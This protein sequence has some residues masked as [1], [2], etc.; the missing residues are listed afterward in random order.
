MN[1]LKAAIREYFTKRN[2][3]WLQNPAAVRCKTQVVVDSLQTL[4]N[5]GG[6]EVRI[7]ET[8]TW[9]YPDGAGL[10]VERRLVTHKQNWARQTNIWRLVKQQSSGEWLPKQIPW[11][12]VESQ[13]TVRNTAQYGTYNRVAACR[14]A[15][16]WWNQENPSYVAVGDDCT[17]FISQ[18]LRAGHLPMSKFD[19]RS[20]GWWYRDE[21]TLQQEGW[22]Y[23][24]A[25][26]NALFTYLITAVKAETTD[27]ADKL[28]MGDI[29]FYDWDGRGTFHHST[30]VTDFDAKGNPLVNAHTDN[31]FRRPY[32]YL[33]SRAFTDKTKYGFVHLPG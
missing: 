14:Y 30:I 26:S 27:S 24:W 18:C 13:A 10:N 4:P 3:G 11:H 20:R 32:R 29:I 17:N 12:Q 9:I 5:H 31:S 15:D 28:R 21:T 33:D 2:S 7:V 8:I 19:N 16:L 23:S 22:S 25:V 6:V 1:D